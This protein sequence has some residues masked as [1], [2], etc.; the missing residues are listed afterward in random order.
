MIVGGSIVGFCCKRILGD[1]IGTAFAGFGCI[2]RYQL[3]LFSFLS[4]LVQCNYYL[5]DFGD[6]GDL[7]EDTEEC[8]CGMTS[9]PLALHPGPDLAYLIISWHTCRIQPC[10]VFP[11]QNVLLDIV[12]GKLS[13]YPGPSEYKLDLVLGWMP[14]ISLTVQSGL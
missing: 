7:G 9:V 1:S 6:L 14:S 8:H 11:G 10:G 13:E 3:V 4:I 12:C 2:S 5:D